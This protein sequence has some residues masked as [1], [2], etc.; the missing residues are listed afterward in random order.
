M[1]RASV[2]GMSLSSGVQGSLWDSSCHETF[3]LHAFSFVCFW[4]WEKMVLLDLQTFP[5]SVILNPFPP[6]F[7]M[8]SPKCR[9]FFFPPPC[10]RAGGGESLW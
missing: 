9:T 6:L 7:S 1:L 3:E 10:Y 4:K 5:S 2:K 8:T